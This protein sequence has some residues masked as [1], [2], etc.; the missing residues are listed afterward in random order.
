MI[1]LA[2][3]I[4]SS[5]E[6]LNGKTDD[7]HN[8]ARRDMIEATHEMQLLVAESSPSLW[9]EQRQIEYQTLSCLRWLVKFNIFTL[10]PSDLT[11]VPY[12]HVAAQ[13]SVPLARLKSVARMAM[14]NGLFIEPSPEHVA[15][16]R[17][18]ASFAEDDHLRNWAHF[19]TTYG[20]PTAAGL[21]EATARWGDTTAK[22]ETAFNVAF[23]TDMPFFEYFKEKKG[24]VDEFAAYMRSLTRSERLRI[25]HLVDGFDWT[26]MGE[27]LIIDVGGSNGQAAATLATAFPNL[28][29]IVQDLPETIVSAKETTL[30]A[31]PP[32]VAAR[33]SFQPHDFFRHQQGR[34]PDIYLLRRILH[35][36]PTERARDILQQL[37]VAIKN[38]DNPRARIIVMETILPPQG[39]LSK[40][41]E[42]ALRARDL[43]MAE[44]FNSKERELNEWEDLFSSTEPPLELKGWKQPQ[45]SALAVMEV[46]LKE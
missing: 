12:T 14:T 42:A 32:P 24:I 7:S 8:L 21:A 6:K 13:A 22:T 44:Y 20:A 29:F 31:L 9:L 3:R 45:G 37:T 25:G 28:R 23:N 27:A 43:T 35:D 19:V 10:V 15:H 40:F 1:D 11:P 2:R 38:G 16:S 5:A 39:V 36:W 4:L 17:L 46:V 41:E 33:I 34:V 18:S 26:G 30:A